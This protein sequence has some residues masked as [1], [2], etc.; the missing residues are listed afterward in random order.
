MPNDNPPTLPRLNMVTT[1]ALGAV[2][3]Q[4]NWPAGRAAINRALLRLRHDRPRAGS[5]GAV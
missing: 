5:G 3:E 4:C 2:A 1:A